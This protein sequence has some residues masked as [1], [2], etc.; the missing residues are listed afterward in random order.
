M[1]QEKSLMTL[2]SSSCTLIPEVITKT[3][4]VKLLKLLMFAV[5]Y[6]YIGEV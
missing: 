3:Q 2:Q 4:K 1:A 6:G 5:L